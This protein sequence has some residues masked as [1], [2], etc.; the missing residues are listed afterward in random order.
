MTYET[1][2]YFEPEPGKL[3]EVLAEEGEG[4]QGGKILDIG[5]FRPLYVPQARAL[6]HFS[7]LGVQVA[8]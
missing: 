6:T 1:G 4:G 5:Q 8:G 2:L 3:A 7:I